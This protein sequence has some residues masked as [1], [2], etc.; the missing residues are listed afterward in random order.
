MNGDPPGKAGYKK[1]CTDFR[2]RP[3]DGRTGERSAALSGPAVRR[4]PCAGSPPCFGQRVP[5]EHMRT[6]KTAAESCVLLPHS[7]PGARHPAL[8]PTPVLPACRRRPPPPEKVRQNAGS[9]GTGCAGEASPLS[10]QKSPAGKARALFRRH[11][12]YRSCTAGLL[13]RYRMLRLFP[14]KGTRFLSVTVLSGCMA[15]GFSFRKNA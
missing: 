9:G 13:C 2:T 14:C 6:E 7:R 12:V 3:T 10:R 11:A 5:Y 4:L 1:H 15:A 8:L